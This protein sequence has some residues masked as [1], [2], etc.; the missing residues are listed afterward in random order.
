MFANYEDIKFVYNPAKYLI[1][2]DCLKQLPMA[3]KG[4]QLIPQKENGINEWWP[5]IHLGQL[6]W[7]LISDP[8]YIK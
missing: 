8:W 6:I 3:I 1:D 4:I 2:L 7:A 5:Q